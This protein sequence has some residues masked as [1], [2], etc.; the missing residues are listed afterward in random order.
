MSTSLMF[1]AFGARCHD[2]MRTEYRQGAVYF[3]IQTKPHK[4][5]CVCCRSR[6]VTLYEANRQSMLISRRHAA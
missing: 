5:R 1:H 2:Y 3:H 6:K 4:R